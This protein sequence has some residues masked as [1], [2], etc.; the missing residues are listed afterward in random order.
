VNVLINRYGAKSAAGVEGEGVEVEEAGDEAQRQ[1]EFVCKGT[2][3]SEEHFRDAS[4]AES[5]VGGNDSCGDVG[6]PWMNEGDS[7]ELLIEPS[8]EG[9][10]W[11]EVTIQLWEVDKRE[12][13]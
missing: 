4:A 5:G 6:F 1:V 11:V 13:G 8:T 3:P 2:G 7:G 12:V 10:R 9:V